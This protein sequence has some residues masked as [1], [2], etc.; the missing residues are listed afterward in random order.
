[1]LAKRK[2]ENPR[3]NDKGPVGTSIVS[4]WGKSGK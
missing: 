1:M 3:H 2:I 4:T